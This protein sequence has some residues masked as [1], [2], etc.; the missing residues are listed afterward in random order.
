M[1]NAAKQG[2]IYGEKAHRHFPRGL[3]ILFIDKASSLPE[4]VHTFL[5]TKKRE[6]LLERN[7]YD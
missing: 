2:L 5:I 1:S 7:S 3:A 4:G 6:V